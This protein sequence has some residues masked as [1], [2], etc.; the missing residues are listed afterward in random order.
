[1]ALLLVFALVL[2]APFL[3]YLTDDTFIHFQF[4]KHVVQGRGFSFNADEPTYGATSPLWVF[5][6]SATGIVLPVGVSAPKDASTMP[7]LAWAAKLYG[8]LFHALAVWLL[9]RVGRRLGWDAWTALAVGALLAVHAWAV[10]WSL[11]GMESPLATACVAGALL[12]LAGVFLEGKRAIV[13]GILLGLSALAR[14]ECYLLVGIAAVAVAYGVER[15]RARRAAELLIGAGLVL[16]PWLLTA[17]AWFHRLLPN[18][19]AAKAGAWLNP[20]LAVGAIQAAVH[21]ELSTDALLLALF[22]LVLAFGSGSTA[23]PAARG[24]RAFWV[25]IASWP[26][27]LVLALASGGVQVVSRYLLPA[28][29]CVLLLGV[30]SLRWLAASSFPKRQAAALPLLLGV[31]AAQNLAITAIVSVPHA[32]AHTRGLR[33]SVVALGIWARDHTPA[34]TYFAV[35][36]IGAFGYYSER[37]VL[38]LYGLV[39]PVMAP[40]VVREGYD[41]VVERLLFERAGRPDYLIDR[42]PLRARLM[43]PVEVPSPYRFMFAREIAN[44]GITRPSRYYYSVYS[45][46][47]VLVDSTREHVADGGAVAGDRGPEY[48]S[49]KAPPSRVPG[50]DNHFTF[51]RLPLRVP[52]SS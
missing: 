32:R 29:P 51:N 47:W 42:Y 31:F 24:R 3:D 39:T 46:D 2:L 5:L 27:L 38:D 19:A 20:G 14:P 15:S 23:L 35:A 12:A 50:G 33:D 28:T 48:N 9:V 21:I 7:S 17:W 6:L 18:T 34:R 22:A 25:L 10:R 8:A 16:V 1:L 26:P 45:I 52:A 36:D 43:R 4:A 49:M 44:L 11:S 41:G 30:A 13:A 37:R 40:I